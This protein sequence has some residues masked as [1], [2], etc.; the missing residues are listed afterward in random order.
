MCIT[1]CVL[2]KCFIVKWSFFPSIVCLHVHRLSILMI[3]PT[4]IFLNIKLYIYIEFQGNDSPCL[5]CQ[6]VIL[7]YCCFR[8]RVK[9]RV[10]IKV[11]VMVRFSYQAV[12]THETRQSQTSS[13]KLVSNIAFHY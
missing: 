3:L 7:K 1:C 11:M 10:R 6:Q 4:S 13:Q 12:F 9:V 5:P 8:F 2:I